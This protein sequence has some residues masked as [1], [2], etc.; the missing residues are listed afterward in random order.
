MRVTRRTIATN[1]H[2]TCHH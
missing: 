1:S 2:E